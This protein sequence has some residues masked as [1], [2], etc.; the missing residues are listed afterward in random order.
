MI[1]RCL[2]RGCSIAPDLHSLPKRIRLWNVPRPV[3]PLSRLSVT[4][5][6]LIPPYAC[7]GLAGSRRSSARLR[8]RL[9]LPN[10]TDG[11]PL[12]YAHFPTTDRQPQRA[13]CGF[14]ACVHVQCTMEEQAPCLLL[15]RGR[16]GLATGRELRSLFASGANADHAALSCVACAPVDVLDCPCLAQKKLVLLPS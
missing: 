10:Q 6:C 4:Q 5:S 3:A 16:R 2:P 13:N 7:C 8:W 9:Q 1:V 12:V 15:R 11:D 14:G